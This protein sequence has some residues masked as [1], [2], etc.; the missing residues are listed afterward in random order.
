MPRQFTMSLFLMAAVI[1]A[2]DQAVTRG[3]YLQM[4]GQTSITIR[5]RTNVASNSI[6]EI[7]TSFGTYPTVISD[8]ASTTNHTIIVAGLTAD[9]KYYYR[10]GSTGAMGASD[11]QRFFNTLPLS[12]TT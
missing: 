1:I 6:V 3:P 8:A 12:S 10:V 4:G 5:W 9:T 2:E 7:G 11:D